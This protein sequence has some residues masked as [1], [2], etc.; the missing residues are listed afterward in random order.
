[1]A[2]EDLREVLPLAVGR[3]CVELVG[4]L[5]LA[6][7]RPVRLPTR[8][9]VVVAGRRL[10]RNLV[11]VWV[12]VRVGDRVRVRVGVRVRV[13]VRVRAYLARQ[14]EA[15]QLDGARHR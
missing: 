3:N 6:Q 8:V 13:R 5:D 9:G 7:G 10:L 14:L 15:R 1:M 4:R 11:R 12:R 2:L